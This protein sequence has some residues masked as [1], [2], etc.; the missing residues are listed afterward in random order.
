MGSLSL[1]VE[2]IQAGSL[3]WSN[4]MV[5][6]GLLGYLFNGV[7]RVIELFLQNLYLRN[8]VLP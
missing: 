8:A 6:V 4:L 7:C 2:I 3:F 5:F 1:G